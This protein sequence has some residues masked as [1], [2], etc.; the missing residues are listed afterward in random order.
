[1]D[2][3]ELGIFAGRQL[4]AASALLDLVSERWLRALAVKCRQVSAVVLFALSYDGEIRCLPEEPEDPAIRDLVNRHQ[5]NDKGFG[6][7]LGPTAAHI[8]G[9]CFTDLG[10]HVEYEAS[11]WI[12]MPDPQGGAAPG[13]RGER[14]LQRALI[15]GWAAAA[16]DLAPERR[17][18]IEGWRTRRL[19]HLDANRSRLTVG[20]VDIAAWLP[21]SDRPWSRG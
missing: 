5:R 16:A 4:V 14:E 2:S 11:P 12:L 9:Q 18:S 6:P 20:H 10:Y 3:P 1:M 17:A 13:P 21:R 8:A 19:A 7:A 15:D